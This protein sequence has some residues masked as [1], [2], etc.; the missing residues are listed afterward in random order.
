MKLRL[1]VLAVVAMA[2]GG[3]GGDGYPTG[4]GA[5]PGTG[6]GT[7]TGSGTG[8]GNA[9]TSATVTMTQGDDGYGTATFSFSPAAVTIAK[10]G[11]ITW[12]NEGGTATHNV[13][14]AATAGAPSNVGNFSSGS[15][16]R[17]F[18]TAGSYSYQCTNHSGM[19]GTVTVQ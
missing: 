1:V 9:P 15:A 12:S 5:G 13:T 10:G 4:T 3:G 8:T 17:T 6:T 7:G 2:C 14:F 11:A 18:N 16:S 19:T